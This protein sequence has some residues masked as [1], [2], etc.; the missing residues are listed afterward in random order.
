[1]N[2]ADKSYSKFRGRP[3]GT[4]FRRRDLSWVTQRIR[5]EQGTEVGDKKVSKD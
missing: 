3:S 1:M 5:L 2:Y 4:A